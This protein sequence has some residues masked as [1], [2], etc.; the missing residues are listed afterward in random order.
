MYGKN[1]CKVFFLFC[2]STTINTKCFCAQMHGDFLHTPSKPSVLRQAPVG[3]PPIQC[4][5]VYL[6]VASDYLPRGSIRSHRLRTQSKDCFLFR[7]RIRPV[8]ILI[9]WLQ[10]GAL[11]TPSLGLINLQEWLTELREAHLLIYHKWYY[12]GHR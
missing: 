4:W 2:H 6:E 5:A 1:K 9:K 10:V 7:P 8:E 11:M 3:Y 12:K